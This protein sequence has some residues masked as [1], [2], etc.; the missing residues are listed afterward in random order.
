MLV[1]LFHAKHYF[2]GQIAWGD[3]LFQN[4][5]I[6]VPIF[7]VLSGFIMVYST[8]R[9]VP[10]ANSLYDV[11]QF[12]IKRIIRIIPLYYFLTILFL[13]LEPN[14]TFLNDGI[15]RLVKVFLFLPLGRLPP[16]YVGW[17]LNYE[18]F[19]YLIFAL[20]LLFFKR[21]FFLY[22]FFI[23]ILFIPQ[24]IKVDQYS[25]PF[26]FLISNSLMLHFL[27]GVFLGNIYPKIKFN[28]RILKP[29]IF[30]GIVAFIGY[31]FSQQRSFILDLIFCGI[32]VFS[33]LSADK[34]SLKLPKTRFLNYLGDISYS[35][36]LVHPLFLL[37]L[38]A[39]FSLLIKDS[40]WAHPLMDFSAITVLTIGASMATHWLIEKRLTTYL[41]KHLK[42]KKTKHLQRTS[43][44]ISSSN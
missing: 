8:E 5:N 26:L 4:G 41:R 44:I 21:Y 17:T 42:E 10:S 25:T 22:V 30:L 32:L 14:N 24:F 23:L 9:P 3:I 35:I 11:K 2:N 36:Y 19:F 27:L 16:L 1:F 38:P 6:G 20:S 13:I 18:M 39:S 33:L 7:F 37:F 31:Y 28:R 15:I 40:F 12:L 29:I 34:F 43:T